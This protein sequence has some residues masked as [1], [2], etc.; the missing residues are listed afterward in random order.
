MF[1]DIHDQHA[2]YQIGRTAMQTSISE[3]V[4]YLFGRTEIASDV[5]PRMNEWN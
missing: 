4:E 5:I 2:T 3:L 1:V